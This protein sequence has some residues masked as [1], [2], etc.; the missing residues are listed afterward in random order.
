VAA[1]SEKKSMLCSIN[2]WKRPK[3]REKGRMNLVMIERER[4]RERERVDGVCGCLY[5]L[6][7]TCKGKR[8]KVKL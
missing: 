4:E 3:K 6:A 5:C 1:K 8:C 2:H 7:N